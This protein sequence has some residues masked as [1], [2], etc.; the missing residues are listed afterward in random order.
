[1]MWLTPTFTGLSDL[2]IFLGKCLSETD[3]WEVSTESAENF[4]EKTTGLLQLGS[5]DQFFLENFYIMGYNSKNARNGKSALKIPKWPSL[6]PLELKSKFIQQFEFSE[7]LEVLYGKC[8]WRARSFSPATFSIQISL[9]LKTSDC[10]K[11]SS[12]SDGGLKFG[13]FDIFDMLF[14]FLAFVKL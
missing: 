12:F 10:H 9:F 13:H 6:N 8:R 7:N 3:S 11:I 2:F 1:M 4:E 5:R 14:P